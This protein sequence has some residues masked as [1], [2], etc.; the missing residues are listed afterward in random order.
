MSPTAVRENQSRGVSPLSKLNKKL[1]W[2]P[3]AKKNYLEQTKPKSP[4]QTARTQTIK[5]GKKSTFERLYNDNKE[6]RR[7]E[8]VVKGQ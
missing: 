7:K 4:P 3:P 1:S 5:G 8:L 2:K 6:E